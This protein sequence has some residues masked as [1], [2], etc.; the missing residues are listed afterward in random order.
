[1]LG[2]GI[3]AGGLSFHR[4]ASGKGRAAASHPGA[5]CRPLSGTGTLVRGGSLVTAR[6]ETW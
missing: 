1:M 5:C 4:L 2:W 3:P 6:T